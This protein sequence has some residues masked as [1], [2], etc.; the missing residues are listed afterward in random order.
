MLTGPTNT[1]VIR[2]GVGGGDVPQTWGGGRGKPQEHVLDKVV[3]VKLNLVL[4]ITFGWVEID[5][6]WRGPS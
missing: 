5:L 4:G 2:G 3:L 1:T 6:R